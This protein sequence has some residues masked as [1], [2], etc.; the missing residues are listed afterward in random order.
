MIARFIISWRGAVGA[1]NG[2]LPTWGRSVIRRGVSEVPLVTAS[3]RMFT[4]RPPP[5][6]RSFSTPGMVRSRAEGLLPHE[7]AVSVPYLPTVLALR[8]SRRLPCPPQVK[9]PSRWMSVQLPA[10]YMDSRRAATAGVRVGTLFLT[11]LEA[12]ARLYSQLGGFGDD[13]GAGA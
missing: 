5:L 11:F 9:P 10:G 8:D 4:A 3:L 2:T 12:F 1:R 13:P 6:L 7:S